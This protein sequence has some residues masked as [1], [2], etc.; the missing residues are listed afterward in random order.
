M[1]TLERGN[2]RTIGA[3]FTNSSGVATDPDGKAATLTVYFEDG[4]T[5]LSGKTMTRDSTGVYS[6]LL[7]T[8]SSDSLGKY[9][10]EISAVFSTT[11]NVVNR[12]IFYL[13]DLRPGD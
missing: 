13:T 7:S 5:Y 8:S 1:I 9:I 10:I 6:Y 2:T 12:E 4:T 3:T 11:N